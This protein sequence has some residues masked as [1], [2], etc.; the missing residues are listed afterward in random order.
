MRHLTRKKAPLTRGDV[1]QSG[2]RPNTRLPAPPPPTSQSKLVHTDILQLDD[3]GKGKNVL[4][5]VYTKHE[6]LVGR[7]KNVS[8][9][10][11]FMSDNTNFVPDNMNF[12]SDNTNFVSDNTNFVS[13]NMN[14]C[15]GQTK[16]K[17]FN[18]C[19]PTGCVI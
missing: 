4:R 6:F 1:F 14:F 17:S 7:D 8:D 10:T 13:D 3:C 15:V 18:F 2:R 5:G 12:V 19:R 11:N 9:N 16:L